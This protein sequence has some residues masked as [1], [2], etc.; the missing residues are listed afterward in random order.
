M[1]LFSRNHILAIFKQP[2]SYDCLKSALADIIT[3]VKRLTDI[4]V[5]EIKFRVTFFGW[6]LKIPSYSYW[7]RF[8]FV[9]V[10]M[11]LV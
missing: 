3:D 8:S 6:G 5:D 10:C 9:N 4:I 1:L 11:H 7:D 2:E